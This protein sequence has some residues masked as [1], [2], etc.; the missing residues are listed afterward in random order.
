MRSVEIIYI[1][2][3]FE[4]VSLLSLL[5][6]ISMTFFARNWLLPQGFLYEWLMTFYKKCRRTR[7][8]SL[9]SV[10]WLLN[11]GSLHCFSPSGPFVGFFKS[12]AYSASAYSD[13]T[14]SNGSHRNIYW[15]IDLDDEYHIRHKSSNNIPQYPV[16][17][18]RSIQ[19]PTTPA[20][21]IYRFEA[22]WNRMDR[23]LLPSF[24]SSNSSSIS[25]L[26]Q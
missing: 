25:L 9:R 17:L 20:I 6:S 24:L 16:V 1:C 26:P 4:E 13:S 5:L 12:V 14:Q 10:C 19:F 8:M 21:S 11:I 23:C 18:K 22:N 2:G 3:L 15:F 7:T